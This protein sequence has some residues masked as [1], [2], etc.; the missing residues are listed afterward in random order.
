MDQKL[1]DFLK[2]VVVLFAVIVIGLW[3]WNNVVERI[4]VHNNII[5][6]STSS[7]PLKVMAEKDDDEDDDKGGAKQDPYRKLFADSA[8]TGHH[9]VNLTRGASHQSCLD[10]GG[11]IV[12][13]MDAKLEKTPNGYRRK[14]KCSV[15]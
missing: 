10:R 13:D 6:K 1:I 3:L 15:K 4:L 8:P 14:N 12:P 9:F 5:P 7:T 11:Q 2:T